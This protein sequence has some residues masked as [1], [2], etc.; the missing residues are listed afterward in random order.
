[1]DEAL[2]APAPAADR[3]GGTD[4]SEPD[5][6]ES[7][8]CEYQQSRLHYILAFWKVVNRSNPENYTSVQYVARLKY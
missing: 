8:Y 3:A 5:F 7:E 6:N 1:M 2:P 4:F